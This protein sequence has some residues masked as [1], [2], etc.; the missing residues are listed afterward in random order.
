MPNSKT[1]K[2]KTDERVSVRRDILETFQIFLTMPHLGTQKITIC[3]LSQKGIA[4]ESKP[5][6]QLKEGSSMECYLHL[7][8]SIRIPLKLDVV[9]IADDLGYKRAGCEI[10]DMGTSAY[11]AYKNFVQLL[12]SLTEFKEIAN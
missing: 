9:H 12:M 10:S 6:L 4:F 3:D 7:N 8:R 5:G 2:S 11:A 1:T